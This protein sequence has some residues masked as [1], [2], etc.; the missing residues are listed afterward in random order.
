MAR[1]Y[2]L[3]LAGALCAVAALPAVAAE[4]AID[5]PALVARALALEHGE[6][7]PRDYSQAVSL[8][9]QAAKAGNGDAQF[10]LGWMYANGR[11]MDR[12][13]AMAAYFFGLAANQGH[14]Q[15]K[16]MLRFVSGSP[17]AAPA[18][19][20]VE[21]KED[22][23]L[24][25]DA[26]VEQKQVVSLIQK[27][28]PEYAIHPRLAFAIVAVES[29][30]KAGAV[31]S[32]NAQGLMQLIPETAE[33]FQVKNVFDPVQNLRGG[34][35]YLRWLLAYFEGDVS[36]AAAGYNAGEGAVDKFR[37]IPPYQETQ[38]Y[39]KRIQT[40]YPGKDHPFDPSVT[41]PSQ[42]LPDIRSR[43]KQG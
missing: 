30:F 17:A 4:P 34:L 15:A 41:S 20:K 31:S 38:A 40:L 43:T 9:C 42:R 6:G 35:A 37:G 36:L 7:V 2:R 22:E 10:N 21:E 5:A 25:A 12:D 3:F 29:N 28:A 1:A 14:V 16:N 27:L 18:C 13:D 11:G 19:M 26:T 24:P 23:L 33:R 39:V 32:K 8:Y